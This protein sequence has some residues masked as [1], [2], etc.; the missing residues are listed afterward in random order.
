MPL[1][2]LFH[3]R[4]E[5]YNPTAGC[6]WA[7]LW[8]PSTPNK[9][10]YIYLCFCFFYLTTFRLSLDSEFGMIHNLGPWVSGQRLAHLPGLCIAWTWANW[11]T[12]LSDTRHKGDSKNVWGPACANELAPHTCYGIWLSS[13]L[14]FHGHC[15]SPVE[16]SA[17][18][19]GP[20]RW[21][22]DPVVIWVLLS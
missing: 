2:M 7:R 18:D 6:R 12:L 9:V 10:G 4:C 21:N 16:I 17:L 20:L 14:R 8:Q 22:Q 11:P 5:L 15:F 1:P 3:A 13:Y 19:S